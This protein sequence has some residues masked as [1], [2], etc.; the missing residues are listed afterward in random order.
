MYLREE[1]IAVYAV[2]FLPLFR[3]RRMF[4]ERFGKVKERIGASADPAERCR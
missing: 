4:L 2:S 3:K 1:N